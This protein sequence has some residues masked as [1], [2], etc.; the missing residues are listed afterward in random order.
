M[1]CIDFPIRARQLAAQAAER[2]AQ[3]IPAHRHHRREHRNLVIDRTFTDSDGKRWIVDYKTSSHEGTGLDAFLDRERA[4][5][6]AE[7]EH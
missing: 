5:Y 1:S 7:L 2:G 3:R 6:A 4:R